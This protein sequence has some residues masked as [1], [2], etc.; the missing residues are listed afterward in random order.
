M[1]HRHFFALCVG[2]T[3]ML[4]HLGAQERAADVLNDR[5]LDLKRPADR[6]KA[7]GRM[8]IIEDRRLQNARAR[9]RAL[10]IPLVETLP[11]G[12][13]RQLVDFDAEGPVF[14]VSRNTNAAIS[15]A[16][17]LTWSSPHTLN[18][19]GLIVG[20]WDGG[21]GRATHQEFATGSRLVNIDTGSM[22]AH[23][24][25]IAGTIGAFGVNSSARGMANASKIHSYN[26]TNDY[27]EMTSAG[28]TAAGQTETKIY[29]SNHSYGPDDGWAS[30]TWGGTGTDQ[31][32]YDVGFGQYSSDS[33]SIDSTIY[34][35]PY[36]ASFWACGN[37]RSSNPA[38]GSTVTINGQS[39]TY[40]SAIHPPGD[41]VYRGG[42]ETINAESIG[43]NIIAIGAVN[44]AVNSGLRDPSKGTIADFSST[45]PA[46]DGRIKP[47]LVANGV[48]L[49]STGIGSDTECVS[50]SGTSMASPNACGSATLLVDQYKRL[51]GGAMR[52]STLKAL[53]IHTADD[54]G[55]PGPDYFYGWGLINVKKGADLV[56][57][58]AAFPAAQQ[59]T[60]D[61][62]SVTTTLREYSFV[63]DGS[64][65]ITATIAWTD[66]AA[67]AVT[68]HDSRT[69][70]LVNNLNL[71]IIAP[72]GT[73]Y[74][75]YTMPFV[76]TWTLASMSQNATTGVNNVDNVEQ[77]RIASP[78]QAGVWRAQVSYAGAIT[79]TTQDFG[80]IISGLMQQSDGIILQSPN[81]GDFFLAGASTTINWQSV[82]GG[83]V[84]I[85]LFNNGVLDSVIASSTP[86]DGSHAWTIPA[87]AVLGSKYRIR[88]TSLSDDTKFD[89]SKNDFTISEQRVFYEQTMSTDPG[90][91]LQG[92]WA[93]G[94]PSG[95][96][97]PTAGFTGSNVLGY[98]L[99]GNYA[100][101][102][103]PTAA[104]ST[105]I[106]CSGYGSVQLSFRRWL[107]VEQYDTA[108]ILVSN[109]GVSWTQVWSNSTTARTRD[110]AWTLVTYNISAVADGKSTVYL[111]WNLGPTDY[112]V[113]YTGWN[114][115]DVNLTGF[116]TQ[117]DT[118]LTLNLAA[119]TV[120]EA[121]G[122][123][124]TT[125]TVSRAGTTGDLVVS[126]ASSNTS[127]ITVPTSVTIP[128]GQ[129]T[130]PSFNINAV[131]DLVMESTQTVSL[132]ATASGY[133]PGT[134]VINIT[135]NDNSPPVVDAGPPQTI[136]L[137]GSSWTP[138][139]I[140]PGLW[141][142]ADATNTITLNGATV[143][144]WADKSGFNRHA[145]AASTAQ[146]TAT[147][148]G[149]NG[150][151]VLTFDGSTDVLN[152]D[153]DF[154]AGVNHSTFI[155]TKPT[156]YSN[157]YG[158]ANASAGA[159]SLHVGFSSSTSYRM[160]FWGNDYAPAIT[161]NFVA[162][163]ANIMNYVWT[164]GTS[165]QI[166][167]N[168]KSEGTSTSPVPGTIGTMSG[169]GRIGRTT[170]HAFFGGDIAEF[171]AVTGAVSAAERQKMEGYL[172]H[173][174]GLTARLVDAHPYKTN[175]PSNAQVAANLDGTVSD[176][177][178]HSLTTTWTIVG[179]PAGVTLGN[180]GTVDTTATFTAAGTYTLRLTADDGFTQVS[181]DVVITVNPPNASLT[182]D[183][184][185]NTG[186][187]VPVDGSSPYTSGA[188]VTVLGNNGSLVRTGY[189]FAGWNTAANGS[190]NAYDAGATFS[191]PDANTTLY[192]QWTANTYTVTLN[193][194]TGTGGSASVTATYGSA[195]PTATAPTRSGYTFGGYYTATN[196]GGTQYY[197]AAMDSAA[198]WG[199][200]ADTTLYAQWNAV[201][202]ANAGADRLV[203]LSTSVPWTPAQITTAAWYDASDASTVI[204]NGTA[205]TNWNDKSGNGRN[206]AQT[207][208]ANQP[209]YTTTLNGLGVISYDGSND[210]LLHAGSA[211]SF[212]G[213][214]CAFVCMQG[215]G[216]GSYSG[217][218]QW[219][220]TDGFNL[221]RNNTSSQL[222][223]EINSGAG[224]QYSTCAG[225]TSFSVPYIGAMSWDGLQAIPYAN[226]VGANAANV[227]GT[228]DVNTVAAGTTNAFQGYIAETIY[229]NSNDSTVRLKLEGY[230][231]HKWGLVGSLSADHPYK[232]VAPGS[233][234]AVANLDGT[235]SDPNGD[236]LTTT[237]TKVNGPGSV[238]FGNAN[239]VDTTAT[240]TVA[241]TYT[242]RLTTTD[243]GASVADDVVITVY[244][245]S[246]VGPLD[247]FAISA[248]ASPQTAGVPITGITI[249]AQDAA[250]LPVASFA[251][252]VIFGGTGG[253]TGTS[254]SFAAG[255][256]TGI[257]VTPGVA[258]SNLTFTVSD[259][260]GHS[261]S[262]TI[263]SILS[264]Y[265]TWSGGAAFDADAN[266]D[267]MKDGLAWILGAT[268]PSG[269]M[270]GKLPLA[271]SSGGNLRM[272][273]RCLKSTARG[274]AVL[275]LQSSSDLG[276][277]D[278][279]TS[280]EASVPESS[281]TVNGVL[282]TISADADPDFINVIAE[283]PATDTKLFTR[284][285]ATE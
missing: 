37:D 50:L 170:G 6:A 114:I 153:L 146:P 83:N 217:P 221:R 219:S 77:V 69:P 226:G 257:S 7:V 256:L 203:A 112:S 139:D 25:H 29:L 267:G 30:S 246:S 138:V 227:T 34:S 79:N 13:W 150:K 32:A 115:D 263:A 274:A 180:A 224:N 230:L 161:S 60:E 24:M 4:T 168:G 145:T 218:V 154:L 91:T 208:T 26:Q 266:G 51:L 42:F 71:K 253:F 31:N 3:T 187:T 240:F 67:T 5:T 229:C 49:Y 194:E 225:P 172:A 97:S 284:I 125:G 193:A 182:Y 155:V 104:T 232:T 22:S 94:V 102:L 279:W 262:V 206:L 133:V 89:S 142:D 268:G 151:R 53:L 185:D 52:A 66:P 166:L 205:V 152:V 159:N 17:D 169:G 237:W 100:D 277:S 39:V 261:G 148:A 59:I 189:T 21:I 54:I 204:R 78:G 16:A 269:S 247:H 46:D 99:T 179:S 160:N 45:G 64:S 176:A 47:D 245:P 233:P 211:V 183:G 44:D 18:G 36:L 41:G 265:V 198:N 201:P 260:S 123:A 200:D 124:A 144:Q 283:I 126:L 82:I 96:G 213:M 207:T 186:G 264:P 222:Q 14:R 162:G 140:N 197:D 164:A 173:K 236:S 70:T 72:N 8:K 38:N 116:R 191:M 113:N 178:S 107:D 20:V 216:G 223:V 177:N 285:M 80:L 272:T 128:N 209:A 202:V 147:A 65:P 27:S 241:G 15:T 48:A 120:S 137:T 156:I 276:L 239:A 249:T 76:G 181:D 174:W 35:T 108:S 188:T 136:F 184:N 122:N 134:A 212:S 43:K 157:I 56:A 95:T 171:I 121:A 127:K 88:I 28:A 215:S 271:S 1:N 92:Q 259:G 163:S 254:A 228:I 74:F 141:L 23:A 132:T 199:I 131:D 119:S 111:R 243:A 40:N 93:W 33:R 12:G 58:H 103:P 190:G 90:W 258:G 158:A 9:G 143:S 165:K 242:I 273:F 73:E 2:L 196:G 214:Q 86:N 195:M 75:P 149:L 130:S 278:P 84:K 101:D 275:K 251:G 250:N 175:G 117:F 10:G 98:N 192:A 11:N 220:G 87:N 252:T 105:A 109:D 63:W 282:F 280:H 210:R 55:R 57:S 231:A 235:V 281:S 85:E 135:D 255:V 110:T 19:A 244:D 106:D 118:A 248:I 234:T 68:A 61:A 62:V 238:S 129:T 167:A 81:G 270:Q